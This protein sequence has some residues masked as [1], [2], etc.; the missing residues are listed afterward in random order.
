VIVTTSNPASKGSERTQRRPIRV[1]IICDFAEEQWPSM[2]LVGDMVHATIADQHADRIASTLIRPK[3]PFASG[4]SPD[5]PS[6]LFGRFIHYP[7]ELRRIR[8]QFALFHIVDHSY[9][10][11]AHELPPGRAIIT[12]HDIDAFRCLLPPATKR[13]YFF[14]AMTRRILTGM[15]R[16]A[17]VTCDTEATRNEILLNDLL[18]ANRL[19]VVHNGVHPALGP[20]PNYD[21]DA[22]LSRL[23]GRPP[24]STTELMHVGSTIARKRIDTLLNVFADVRQHRSEVR[25]LRIGGEFTAQQRQL[26]Q[27]LG[28]LKHIDVLPRVDESI[29]AAA[30]RRAAIL[31]QT[32]EAEGFG[33]PVIEAMA[34]GTPVIAS[35]IAPLREVGGSAA[36]YCPI[37]DTTQFIYT[38]LNLLTERENKPSTWQTR[39][40]KSLAQACRFTWTAYAAKMAGIY[41]RVLEQ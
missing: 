28:I 3:M 29:L 15:Q 22:E 11:L 13:S 38:V 25:L 33:L 2:D 39:R 32:S 8:D 26:A 37:G 40:S 41:D 36:E 35:D 24:G 27:S 20:E 23:L 6:R 1:A 30:Y 10:H 16:A 4:Q 18:P 7:R 17:H 19:S 12:C 14:R 34:C 21:A 9:A 5:K 31:L